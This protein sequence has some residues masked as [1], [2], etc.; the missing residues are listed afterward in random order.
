MILEDGRGTGRKVRIDGNN[1]MHTQTVTEP[2]GIHS[3]EVGDAYNINT[4]D[5][6][7]SAAGTLLYIK[8]NEDKDLVVEAIAA[9]IGNTGTHSDIGNI[10]IVRNPTGG[11]LISDATAVSMNQNRNFGSNKTLTADAYKGKSAG[12]ITGG[13]NIIQFYQGANGRLF[14]TINLVIPKGGS[15]GISYDPNLS[16]GS[17]NA[18]AAAIVYLKDPE[19]KD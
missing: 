18:Y 6:S 9:G 5:I 2:E 15:I 11:D 17:V 1:R 10:T 19:S 3:A 8:N 12:T 14:A 16:S 7:F 13:N 4:G